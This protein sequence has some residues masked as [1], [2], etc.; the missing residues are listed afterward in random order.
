[1][2][3]QAAFAEYFLR[4]AVYTPL[5]NEEIRT[6]LSTHY[7]LGE[8]MFA[9]G[10]AQGVEN[11]NFLI[12]LRGHAGQEI[13]YILTL[14]E[15]RVKPEEL[16][17]FMELMAHLSARGIACPQ[18]VVMRSGALTGM[19]QSKAF[20]LVSFLSGTSVSI[21]TPHHCAEVGSMVATLHRATVDA[22][23]QRANN[24]GI[25]HWR[26]LA[27]GLGARLNTLQDGL[28]SQV[29]D[30]LATLEDQWPHHLPA[31]IVHADI[32]PDNVFFDEA[33][34]CSGV[35][36]FYFACHDL[37]AYD[38]MIA[39]NAW[40]FDS[41]NHAF[42]PQKS[43]AFF[44]AYQRMRPLSDA[45]KQVLPLLGQGAALR[46]LLTRAHDRLHAPEGTRHL[47]K[48]PLEYAKK[49]AFFDTLSSA[50]WSIA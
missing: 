11:S 27:Q 45:E 46:F 33:G 32:F 20:T 14:F 40:C 29:M 35:I 13:H 17:F 18:P 50:D 37:L 25:K 39:H 34:A 47:T 6:L 5:S 41:E 48:D 19:I 16:P 2:L 4:M 49:L 23:L 12:S 1:M 22:K 9:L 28:Q 30:A 43:S 31:G 10:I 15:K 8:F 38:L 26:T 42:N 3:A 44:T 24:V 7:D 36:D 21:I